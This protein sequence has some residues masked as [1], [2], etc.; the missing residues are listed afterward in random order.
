MTT[1]EMKE[2]I[3]D[4]FEEVIDACAPDL[5]EFTIKNKKDWLSSALDRYEQAIKSQDV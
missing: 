5:D 3:L 1:H 4:E 2:E